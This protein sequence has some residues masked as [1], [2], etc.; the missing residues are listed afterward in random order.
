MDTIFQW[1][2]HGGQQVYLPQQDLRP[3]LVLFSHIENFLVLHLS[4]NYNTK[5]MYEDFC[6][7]EMLNVA[8]IR[9]HK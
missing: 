2:N 8:P 1:N 9:I 6:L 3:K 5:Q 4:F 7:F